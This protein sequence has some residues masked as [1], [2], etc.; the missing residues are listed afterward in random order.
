MGCARSRH[1][2]LDRLREFE[3]EPVKSF[4]WPVGLINK[5]EARVQQERPRAKVARRK[6]GS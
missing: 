3:A 5:L 4:T 6:P 2:D 1:W